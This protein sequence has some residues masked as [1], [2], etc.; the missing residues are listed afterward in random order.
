M[1][2]AWKGISFE[3]SSPDLGTNNKWLTWGS[4]VTTLAILCVPAWGIQTFLP[5]IYSKP[6]SKTFCL[7]L[8]LVNM[9]PCDL[10]LKWHRAHT[11]QYLNNSPN[12]WAPV[13][14]IAT[15]L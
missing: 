7:K 4:L 14:C 12:H 15:T 2:E 5:T 6:S 1:A 10:P 8:Q 11:I 3:G 13:E 9:E